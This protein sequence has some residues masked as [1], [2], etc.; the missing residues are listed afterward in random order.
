[1]TA[2]AARPPLEREG[3]EKKETTW[4]ISGRQCSCHGRRAR[5]ALADEQTARCGITPEINTYEIIRPRRCVCCGRRQRARAS[6]SSCSS[7]S[8]SC[9][10]TIHSEHTHTGW[11]A[12]A[13]LLPC[14]CDGRRAALAGG[15]GGLEAAP[16]L[17]LL[18]RRHFP[19]DTQTL[20]F[21]CL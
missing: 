20:A 10:P 14:V 11:L 2:A 12:R 1:M 4:Q 6:S 8:C 21:I 13:S 19:L 17:A 3:G 7:S 16:G 18:G 9:S 15:G 5:G